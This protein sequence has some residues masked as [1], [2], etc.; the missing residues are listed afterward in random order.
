MNNKSKESVINIMHKGDNIVED[1][2][3]S[4]TQIF[5]DVYLDTI[6]DII[7]SDY[8]VYNQRTIFEFLNDRFIES[9][10]ESYEKE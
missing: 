5:G 2:E 10:K 4:L 6:K 9:V 1:F 8:E 7:F 3:K